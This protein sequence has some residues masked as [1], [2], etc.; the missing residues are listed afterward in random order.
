MNLPQP[1]LPADEPPTP[2]RPAYGG[3]D[4]YGAWAR[5]DFMDRSQ[6]E[7]AEG[8]LVGAGSGVSSHP[9]DGEHPASGKGRRPFVIVLNDPD[10]VA[11]VQRLACRIIPESDEDAIVCEPVP[12]ETADAELALVRPYVQSG[13]RTEA[14]PKPEPKPVE[15][16][17]ETLISSVRM[18]EESELRSLSAVHRKIRALCYM[19][20]SVAEISAELATPIDDTQVV[21]NEAIVLGVLTVHRS[22]PTGENGRPTL[23]LLRR[24]REGLRKLPA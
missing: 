11:E 5:H 13:P 20:Q 18:T 6:F 9:R 23:D 21:I 22:L 10:R 1:P 4:S 24:V 8:R 14:K 3:W 19:P 16:Q 7:D 12:A 2:Q 15:L 17:L